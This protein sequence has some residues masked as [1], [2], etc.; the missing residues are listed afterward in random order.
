MVI[1]DE[2]KQNLGRKKKSVLAKRSQCGLSKMSCQNQKAK[3]LCLSLMTI[4]R[5]NLA[6][7]AT[8][9]DL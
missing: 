2:M 4:S 6:Y 8:Y 1:T 3:R 5:I 9:I 7:T